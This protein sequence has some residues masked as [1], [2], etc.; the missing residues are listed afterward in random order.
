MIINGKDLGIKF[1]TI[2][3]IIKYLDIDPQTVAVTIDLE[4][5][6]PNMYNQELK[7]NEV[8][9]LITFVSGG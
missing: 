9:E 2:S 3:E 4:I 7:G 8:I 5:I 6:E 1:K